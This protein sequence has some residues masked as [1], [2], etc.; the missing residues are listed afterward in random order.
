MA[1]PSVVDGE[2]STKTLQEVINYAS[3]LI[4]SLQRFEEARSLLLQTMPVARRVLGD[5]D[6]LTLR[7]RAIYAEALCRDDGTTLDDIREAVAMLE[8]TARTT[9]RVFGSAHPLTTKIERNL[10]NARAALHAR[11]TQS[12][13]R[14]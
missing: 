10:R 14:P 13:A 4:N 2:E 12:S 7:M 1:G 6:D 8:D 5:N 11:E 9:R 3:S